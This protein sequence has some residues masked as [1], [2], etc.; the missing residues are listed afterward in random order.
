MFNKDLFL[1]L[2]EKYNVELSA[3]AVSPMIKEGE[4]THA[5]TVDDINRVFTLCQ[6]CF[7]YSD[8]K[9]NARVEM[10]VFLLQDDYAIAC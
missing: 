7:G 3:S 4:E 10:P 1:S 6:A 9:I 2:C 5:I 8:C